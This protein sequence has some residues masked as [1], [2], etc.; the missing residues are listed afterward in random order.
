MAIWTAGEAVAAARAYAES[1][2]DGV[3]ERDRS[4]RVPVR[5]LAALDASGLLAIT[6]PRVYGGPELGASALAEVIRV[7]AAVDPAIAQVPQAH[8]LFTDVLAVL[9]TQEQRKRLF[10][11]VLDGGRLGNAQAE[12]GGQHA[13]D[14]K[15]RLYRDSGGGLRLNGTK[16]YTTGSLTAR[17]L[18]VTALDDTGQLVLAFV[19]RDAPGVT[20]DTDW[21]V[22]GQRA[23]VSGSAVFADVPADPA[24]VVPY[25][26][27]FA[28]PQQLGARTQLVHAAIQ[29][30][31]AGGAL[32]DAGWFVR[33]KA[34]PFFEAARAGLAGTASTDPHTIHRYGELATKVSAAEALL[35]QAAAVQESV[36]RVPADEH[37][38]ARGSLAVARVKAFASEVAAEVTTEIFSVG[39]ASAADERYDLS[40]HWRNARTHASHDP[41]SWKYHHIGNYLLNDAL[42]PNH[43]QL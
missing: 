15:T 33:T 4:G 32:R 10:W 30:G 13:Q 20:L 29:V 40:R 16:Y 31:I 8:F 24:L 6:V 37:A 12:R 42:P 28:V 14:L 43:G 27:A 7:I 5:E 2:A 23:T 19:R 38:A 18:G 34:R 36:G 1:I 9:G 39:G 3:I 26:S 11:E 17:W 25:A 41:V 35:A 22:M 21:N